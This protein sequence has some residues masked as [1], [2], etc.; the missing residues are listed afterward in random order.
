MTA[1]N[2]R[3]TDNQSGTGS[4]VDVNPQSSAQ[5]LSHLLAHTT[6]GQDGY[7]TSIELRENRQGITAVVKQNGQTLATATENDNSKSFARTPISGLTVT[8]TK[9]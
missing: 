3:F 2:I 7:V 4:N 5:D 1:V 9:A 6:V 8:V